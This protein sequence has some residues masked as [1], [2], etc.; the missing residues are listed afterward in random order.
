MTTALIVAFI[1]LGVSGVLA[2][3]G[4]VKAAAVFARFLFFAT[5][6]VIVGIG[7]AILF[8]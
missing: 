8:T 7:L 3:T 2:F 1:V 4:L 5:L 6:V